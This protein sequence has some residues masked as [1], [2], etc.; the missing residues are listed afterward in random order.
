MSQLT[1]DASRGTPFPQT[2]HAAWSVVASGWT[3]SGS[4][5][6]ATGE[7]HSVFVLADTTEKQSGRG[8][9]RGGSGGR[10]NGRGRI[11]STATSILSDLGTTGKEAASEQ[12]TET[13]TCRG[14]LKK[15]HLWINC[16]DNVAADKAPQGKQSPFI[17]IG[18]DDSQDEEAIYD[19]C[20]MM[21]ETVFFGKTEVLLDNQASR[22]IFNNSDLLS[23]IQYEN[24]E[25]IDG[26]SRGL[27]VNESGD[28]G[29]LGREGFSKSA[30][31]N[32][33]SK[34]EMLDSGKQV[35]YDQVKDVYHLT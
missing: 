17:A 35:S 14:C 15:G 28:F 5:T 26:T 7:M 21:K 2:R 8:S 31:A 32:V 22:S 19:A 24:I 30:A 10:G 11:E 25:G 3:T 34:T 1:N 27:K 4:K 33:L 16:P 20:F 23:D 6:S 29:G 9:A 12:P 13:C 18:E